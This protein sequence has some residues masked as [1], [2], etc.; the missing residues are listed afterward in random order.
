MRYA[1]IIAETVLDEE[2]TSKN[3][4]FF[5]GTDSETFSSFQPDAAKKGMSHYNP[6]GQGM[7]AT[8]SIQFAG[9]FGRNIHH[10]SIPAGARYK[11][12]TQRQWAQSVG[13]NII[14]KA[15]RIAFKEKGLDYGA[16]MSGR[17]TEPEQDWRHL[18]PGGIVDAYYRYCLRKPV[19]E[20]G[21]TGLTSDGLRDMVA[22]LK[23][24]G[25]RVPVSDC[26]EMMEA[27]CRTPSSA[28]TIS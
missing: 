11:R 23:R 12:I 4:M 18:G 5:H 10:V 28:S 25:P 13:R 21:H 6:L 1:E 9:K 14:T 26:R 3:L 16:W 17:A 8:D 24:K 15:L 7:Y 20:R 19:P 2:V 27:M 22:A